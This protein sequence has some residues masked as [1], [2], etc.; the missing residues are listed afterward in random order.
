MA[1]KTPTEIA[2]LDRYTDAEML[3]LYRWAE[4]TL[5]STPGQDS[6]T[7]DGFSFQRT[8][9][10]QIREGIRVYSNR[11]NGAARRKIRLGAF[12]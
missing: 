4:A 3:A 2:A 1:A 7:K 6:V 10:Q 9:L 11:V 8:N 12:Q 5:V